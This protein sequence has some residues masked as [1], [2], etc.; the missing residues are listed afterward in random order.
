MKI[1]TTGCEDLIVGWL[2]I[3]RPRSAPGDLVVR[4]AVGPHF[5]QHLRSRHRAV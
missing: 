2:W 1:I 5:T 3:S 4:E